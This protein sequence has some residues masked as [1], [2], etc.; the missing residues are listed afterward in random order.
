MS[1]HAAPTKSN[2]NSA[3]NASHAADGNRGVAIAPPKQNRTGAGRA[4]GGN[5]T[6]VIDARTKLFTAA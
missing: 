6:A 5:R 1:M 3:E 4:Q 2:G